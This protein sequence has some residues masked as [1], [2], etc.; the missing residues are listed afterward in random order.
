MELNVD[1]IPLEKFE[2]VVKGKSLGVFQKESSWEGLTK[3]VGDK[4]VIVIDDEGRWVDDLFSKLMPE[5]QKKSCKVIKI[6]PTLVPF[7]EVS[8]TEVGSEKTLKNKER[9]GESDA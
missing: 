4:G 1:L 9:E 5:P 2:V 8:D 6:T 3:L 7:F